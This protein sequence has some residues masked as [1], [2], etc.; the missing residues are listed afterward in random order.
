MADAPLR[1]AP[2]M[3]APPA[4]TCTIVVRTAQST[5][6]HYPFFLILSVSYKSIAGAALFVEMVR[7]LQ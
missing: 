7:I 3:C 5:A 6:S 1:L 2:E 4:C